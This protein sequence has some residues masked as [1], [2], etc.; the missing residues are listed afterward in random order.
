M[1]DCSLLRNDFECQMYG[2]WVLVAGMA[3]IS[4]GCDRPAAVSL[5]WA[6]QSGMEG[7]GEQ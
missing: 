6:A 3:G 7:W 5:S 2:C 1:L 4:V